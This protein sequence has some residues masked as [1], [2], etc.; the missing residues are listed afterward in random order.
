[1]TFPPSN[2]QGCALW[3]AAMKS[4]D[5]CLLFH[6]VSFSCPVCTQ[7]LMVIIVLITCMQVGLKSQCKV[8]RS[9]ETLGTFLFGSKYRVIFFKLTAIIRTCLMNKCCSAPLMFYLSEI[10]H[11]RE[12]MSPRCKDL[13]WIYIYMCVWDFRL[14]KWSLPCCYHVWLNCCS[15]VFLFRFFFLSR[16]LVSACV[17]SLSFPALIFHYHFH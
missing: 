3:P 1:M 14:M 16:E 17:T 6:G 15:L 4:K 12:H 7:C 2:I 10:L 13:F 8:S 11:F 5:C 9:R